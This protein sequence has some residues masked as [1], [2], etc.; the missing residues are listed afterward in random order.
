[1]ANNTAN[2]TVGKPKIG[3]AIYN[4][5]LG[6]TL[7]TDAET[8]L[9]EAFRNLG[10]VSDDGLTNENNL[11]SEKIKAW[12]GDTVLTLQGEKEDNFKF[13]L[14]EVLDI[15]VMKAVYGEENVTGD[16]ETGIT[17]RANAKE[18]EESA[19][20]F[21][22]IMTRGVKKRIVV[23]NAKISELSEIVY[24]DD[25]PVGYDVTLAAMPGGDEFDGDTHKEYIKK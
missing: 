2:V 11:S 4:A 7:P 17:I 20:V 24:K 19:W 12:G 21:D 5:P 8:A 3:G 16:L 13:K 25:D 10:Y 6:T 1:M 23:P 22:M 9:D 15:N 14:I 18:L